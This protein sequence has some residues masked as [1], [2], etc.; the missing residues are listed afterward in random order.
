MLVSDDSEEPTPT[1]ITV[2]RSDR[3]TIKLLALLVGF[4][5]VVVP[6]L[7]ASYAYQKGQ[8]DA[9][10]D[11]ANIQRDLDDQYKLFAGI[12]RSMG[13]YVMN[14]SAI[15]IQLQQHVETID[16]EIVTVRPPTKPIP[17]VPEFTMPSL[18][19]VRRQST[20]RENR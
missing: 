14:L 13:D 19:P 3:R 11:M 2:R 16:S 7:A 12:L 5:M 9:R 1:V 8:A 15:V 18:P 4:G 20:A 10:K 6:A 17:K